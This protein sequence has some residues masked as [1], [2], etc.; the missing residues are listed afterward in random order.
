MKKWIL[1]SALVV[2][3]ASKSF[4]ADVVC[5]YDL[6]QPKQWTQ[7]QINFTGS[8]AYFLSFQLA[9]PTDSTNTNYDI[10]GG[11]IDVTYKNP[12]CGNN[13]CTVITG[14]LIYDTTNWK[15][16]C[17]QELDDWYWTLVDKTGVQ[18]AAFF[19]GRTDYRKYID[20]QD[21]KYNPD[22]KYDL[23]DDHYQMVADECELGKLPYVTCPSSFECSIPPPWVRRTSDVIHL[24]LKE[25]I[26]LFGDPEKRK[27]TND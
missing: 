3:F 2:L 15:I 25:W 12:S 10:P 24:P 23:D 13:V 4:G 9:C 27:K 19:A 8:T 5:R 6:T 20:N 22:A 16:S 14:Q 21:P 11:W 26:K 7:E 17:D 1:L 18:G